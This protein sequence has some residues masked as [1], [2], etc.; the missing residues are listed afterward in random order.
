MMQPSADIGSVAM[1]TALGPTLT[2]AA[3]AQQQGAPPVPED[4]RVFGPPQ[5]WRVRG[6]GLVS[7]SSLRVD[8]VLDAD[9]VST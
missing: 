8:A 2:A 3:A 6:L 9:Q 4:R 1:S 5:R 7:V